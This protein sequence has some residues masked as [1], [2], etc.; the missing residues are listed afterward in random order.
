S[1]SALGSI[2]SFY[3][4]GYVVMQIPAGFLVDKIGKKPVLIPGFI[5]FAL[6]AL[7]IAQAHTIGTIYLGSLLAG[8]GC[9]SF[10][11]SAYA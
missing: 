10:Y 11:G 6:A 4:L 1:D 7:L 3:F 8:L 5:L 2:S 9:G